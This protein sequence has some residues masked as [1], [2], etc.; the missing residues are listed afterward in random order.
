M[1]VITINT[2][3][4]THN[5]SFFRKQKNWT[6]QELA[7]KLKISRSVIAKWEN[8][9]V[10]PDIISLIKL[11]EIFNITLDHLVGNNSFRHDILKEFKRV[12]SSKTT[13]FDDEVIELIEFLM[14]NPTLKQE[15]KRMKNL[16][17]KKQQSIQELLGGL[18]DQF[19]KI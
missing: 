16:P 18:I 14:T 4:I 17:L 19:E 10:T 5:I 15:I 9:I 7:D 1:S 13:P 6:Q 3:I 12:Y 2:E 8:N 11:S